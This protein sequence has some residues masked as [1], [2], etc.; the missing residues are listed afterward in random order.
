MAG[1]QL[2]TQKRALLLD[3]VAVPVFAEAGTT[4]LTGLTEQREH[5]SDAGTTCQRLGAWD[6]LAPRKKG[7]C[8]WQWL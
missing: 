8:R 1:N 4:L 2:P 7:L 6:I 3:E 5:R